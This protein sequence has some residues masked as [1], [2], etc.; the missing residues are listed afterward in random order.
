MEEKP[1]NVQRLDYPA[2]IIN[3]NNKDMLHLLMI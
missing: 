2:I 1:L 3:N